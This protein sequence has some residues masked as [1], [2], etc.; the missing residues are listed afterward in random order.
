LTDCTAI[1]L[2]ADAVR[3]RA[4]AAKRAGILAARGS[5]PTSRLAL[6]RPASLASP[7]RG[8]CGACG[9]V[10]V[11]QRCCHACAQPD[12]DDAT[13]EAAARIAAAPPQRRRALAR[14]APTARSAHPIAWAAIFVIVVI[15]GIAWLDGMERGEQRVLQKRLS[16]LDALPGSRVVDAAAGGER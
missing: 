13:A 4:R 15:S 2:H 16:A 10:L 5:A 6:A 11:D 9:L 7:F 3:A 12:D 8:F 1:V 14:S